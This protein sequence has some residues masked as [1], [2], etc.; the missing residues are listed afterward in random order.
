MG[1]APYKHAPI[2][3]ALRRRIHDGTYP[4]GQRLPSIPELRRTFAIGDRTARA[5]LQT[6]ISEGLATAH[7]RRGTYVSGS[8]ST[9][10]TPS[11]PRPRRTHS[12]RRH[13]PADAPTQETT[14]SPPTPPAPHTPRHPPTSP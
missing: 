4:P 7:R 9:D 3:D 11:Q 6:L 10:T 5:A 1:D 8:T 2:A 14:T 13:R 12:A